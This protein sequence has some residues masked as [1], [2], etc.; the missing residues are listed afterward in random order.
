MDG[1]REEWAN[2]SAGGVPAIRG[3]PRQLGGIGAS[4]PLRTSEWLCGRSSVLAKGR[5]VHR[6]GASS[7]WNGLLRK[8]PL[9]EH[10]LHLRGM[11]RL[12]SDSMF[13]S[14]CRTSADAL[15]CR[16]TP[17]AIGESRTPN[18]QTV[19]EALLQHQANE[20]TCLKFGG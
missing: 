18:S 2:T 16:R 4:Q 7:G 3:V 19:S 1:R 9:C 6:C 12:Y 20:S 15:C 14:T 13:E 5:E 8:R 11:Q 17:A 10:Q